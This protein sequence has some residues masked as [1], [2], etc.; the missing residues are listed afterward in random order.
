MQY[1]HAVMG[2]ISVALSTLRE[3]FLKVYW[4][5]LDDSDTVLLWQHQILT[6]NFIC[7]FR[8]LKHIY[9]VVVQGK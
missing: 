8:M 3:E 2:D 4:I 7:C 9:G 5:V 6:V 1:S